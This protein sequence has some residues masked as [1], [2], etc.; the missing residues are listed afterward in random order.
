MTISEHFQELS[1][2]PHHNTPVKNK[3]IPAW[4]TNSSPNPIISA[5][6]IPTT[7]PPINTTA[8]PS[9]SQDYEFIDSEIPPDQHQ[10]CGLPD[11]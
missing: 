10:V 11:T 8:E 5:S 3:S 4:S 2:E 6:T 1:L 7:M 9:G